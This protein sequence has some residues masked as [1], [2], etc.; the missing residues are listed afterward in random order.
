VEAVLAPADV[1]DPVYWKGVTRLGA[2][3]VLVGESPLGEPIL[4]MWFDAFGQESADSI[5]FGQDVP[6]PP[7]DSIGFA[8]TL[9]SAPSSLVDY[10]YNPVFD[11]VVGFLDH[12]GE[13]APSAVEIA[14]DRYL[15][16]Y[17]GTSAD[18]TTDE[19]I[20]VAVSP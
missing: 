13:V 7:N 18:G 20:G 19:G 12:R 14:P 1:T 5:Q 3:S 2:P 15:L 17:R 11:R 6:I 8:S 4:Q 16:Y 9:V 10:P